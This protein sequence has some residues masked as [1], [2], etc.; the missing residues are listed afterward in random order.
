MQP[1]HEE[2]KDKIMLLFS[3]WCLK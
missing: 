2:V 1:Q 3:S